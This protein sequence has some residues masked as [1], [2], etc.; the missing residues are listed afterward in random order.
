LTCG[1]FEIIMIF[2]IDIG[3]NESLQ[4]FIFSLQAMLIIVVSEVKDALT[5]NF[6]E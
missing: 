6:F 5:I 4:L 3:L 1:V 2:R